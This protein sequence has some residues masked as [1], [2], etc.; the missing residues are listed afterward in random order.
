M[1][2]ATPTALQPLARPSC[3]SWCTVRDL[4]GDHPAHFGDVAD[5]H[6]PHEPMFVEVAI[7]QRGDAAPEVQLDTDR[8]NEAGVT[9]SRR[10]VS[11][12]PDQAHAA[13]VFLTGYD[14]RLSG[15]LLD[16]CGRLG[17]EDGASR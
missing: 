17:F 8:Y 1:K 9:V 14:E 3:P 2:T 4:F 10:I 12:T 5:W 11:L 16:A 13:G 15:A 6:D 7:T